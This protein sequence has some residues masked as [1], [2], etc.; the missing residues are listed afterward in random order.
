MSILG[1]RFVFDRAIGVLAYCLDLSWTLDLLT[2]R[3]RGKLSPR[4]LSKLLLQG[5]LVHAASSY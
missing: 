4:Q 1:Y 3:H 2:V 5:R